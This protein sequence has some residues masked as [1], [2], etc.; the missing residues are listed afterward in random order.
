[1][2][3]T[4]TI[5]RRIAVKLGLTSATAEPKHVRVGPN[6]IHQPCQAFFDNRANQFH[7]YTK[8]KAIAK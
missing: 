4:V 3:K 8:T 6:T 2:A 1:M 5:P 7:T